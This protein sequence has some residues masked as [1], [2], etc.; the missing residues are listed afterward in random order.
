VNGGGAKGKRLLRPRSL[1]A[2][3]R[4]GA[5]STNLAV[6]AAAAAASIDNDD[7]VYPS[8]MDASVDDALQTTGTGIWPVSPPNG[9]DGGV[10][11]APSAA[12]ASPG[13]VGTAAGSAS[14]AAPAPDADGV[15]PSRWFSRLLTWMSDAGPSP[16]PQP[17]VRSHSDGTKSLVDLGVMTPAH[18]DIVMRRVDRAEAPSPA[19]ARSPAPP[20][21][22][23]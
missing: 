3:K 1:L 5:S 20:G 8:P 10:R 9:N 13:S 17:P 22:A 12:P 2:K 4:K 14:G 6:V 18:R 7:A 23:E 16:L 11:R 21:A 15:S 19:I